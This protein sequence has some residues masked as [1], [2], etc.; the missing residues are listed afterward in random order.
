MNEHREPTDQEHEPT[1]FEIW[2]LIFRWIADPSHA[3]AITAIATC[4]ICIT[5]IFYTVFA[6]KQWIANKNAA[7]AAKSAAET[8][9]QTLESV[10]RAYLSSG[11]PEEVLGGWGVIKIP[12]SNTG[13]IPTDSTNLRLNF[14]RMTPQGR[15]LEDRVMEIKT[16]PSIEPGR[17]TYFLVIGMPRTD[18][19]TA[20][21]I[22]HRAQ[23]LLVR[24]HLSYGNGF[25]KSDMLEL[26]YAYH[27]EKLKWIDCSRDTA[28]IDLNDA[29]HRPEYE[30]ANNQR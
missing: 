21:A 13:H 19:G 22:T 24:G 8:A 25:G 16:K 11:E 15:V 26:C 14:E 5:G 27:P 20:A 6:G 30:H 17:N 9:R 3:N 1:P 29:K 4:V 10:D 7:D 2:S 18:N 28:D 23:I 12:I